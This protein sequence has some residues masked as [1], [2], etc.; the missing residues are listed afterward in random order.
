VRA[1]GIDT[2][3]WTAS[4]GVVVDGNTRLE[5]S[6]LVSGSHASTL[7]L[8]LDETLSAAGLRL[9]DLDLIAISSGPGSFTGL[10]IG[11]S[12]VKGL[13]LAT[14][15][16]VIGVPTLEALAVAAGPR[17]GLV[18]PVLDARKGEVYAAVFRW[19]EGVL[20][21][22]AAPMAIAPERLAERVG[23]ACTLVGAGVEAYA[24]L[25]GLHFGQR[26]TLI[27][28][29]TVA[30]SGAVIAALGTRRFA[31][32][33]GADLDRLEPS[34]VRRSEA[35]IHRRPVRATANPAGVEKLTG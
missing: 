21:R 14:G 13:A 1:L 22:V 5:R 33:G 6:R 18:C 30:P 17:E 11:L 16:A 3:T 26:A 31:A 2:A 24:P 12:V 29:G 7:L 28:G 32:C 8:L 10:R 20:K 9:I 15:L 25:W 27:D 34:Y 4:A 23:G 35:E 19:N